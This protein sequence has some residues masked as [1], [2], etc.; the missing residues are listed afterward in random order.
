MY[1][2]KTAL[3]SNDDKRDGKRLIKLH[4]ILMVQVL[5]KYAKQSC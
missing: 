2:L 3:S 5:G 1:I 4:H